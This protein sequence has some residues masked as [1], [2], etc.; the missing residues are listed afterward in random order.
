M[1]GKNKE[2]CVQIWM[3]I[4]TSRA[5]LLFWVW[6]DGKVGFLLYQTGFLVLQKKKKRV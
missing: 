5:C 2:W 3:M 1:C 6:R 4:M